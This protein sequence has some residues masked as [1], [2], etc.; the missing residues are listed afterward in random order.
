[1]QV[2]KV[3][4]LSLETSGFEVDYKSAENHRILCE[5]GM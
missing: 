5:F 2:S 1:M 4:K 3:Y